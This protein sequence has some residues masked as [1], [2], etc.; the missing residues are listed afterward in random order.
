MTNVVVA[1]EKL[2]LIEESYQTTKCIFETKALTYH[3]SA[4]EVLE[5]MC[6]K[7]GSTVKGRMDAF[8]KIT[9]TKQKPAVLIS[10][11]TMDLYF[12]LRSPTSKE[13]T[14]VLFDA[15]ISYHS[16]AN[17]Q[18]KLILQNQGEYIVP[19]DYRTVQ[20]QILRCSQYIKKLMDTKKG[21]LPPY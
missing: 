14:W 9:N 5:D 17:K 20:N 1:N 10:E 21:V 8:K 19:Y 11:S 7:Y 13:N 18:T 2:L 12:P 3:V 4:L 15:I 6:L 16:F